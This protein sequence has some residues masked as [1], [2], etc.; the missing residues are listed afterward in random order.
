MGVGAERYFHV[1]KRH[2]A[3]PGQNEFF[4]AHLKQQVKHLG[5][6]HIPRP[7]LLLDHVETGTFNIDLCS[8]DGGSA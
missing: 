7:Y 8:H 2:A 4:A 5:I 6:Q 3:V 1:E